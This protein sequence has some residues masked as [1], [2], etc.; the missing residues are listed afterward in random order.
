MDYP[1]SNVGGCTDGN[2]T[3]VSYF[4]VCIND[5]VSMIVHIRL[6]YTI[7]W[8]IRER[9]IVRK[10]RTNYAAKN[11]ELCGWKPEIMRDCA[12]FLKVYVL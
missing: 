5:N 6:Q 10:K 4:M 12:E 11:T 9:G 8:L 1:Q 3:Q 2:Q 7:T